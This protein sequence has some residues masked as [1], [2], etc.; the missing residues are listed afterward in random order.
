MADGNDRPKSRSNQNS[1]FT[2]H[3]YYYQQYYAVQQMANAG[4]VPVMAPGTEQQMPAGAAAAGYAW[5]MYPTGYQ[6]VHP[7]AGGVPAYYFPYA[8]PAYS[9]YQQHYMSAQQ[10]PQQV[11]ATSVSAESTSPGTDSVQAQT[12]LGNQNEHTTDPVM[13][14]ST[15]STSSTPT[16]R[17]LPV[18]PSSDGISLV[19]KVS[20]GFPKDK[21]KW[22]LSRTGGSR[23]SLA[24]DGTGGDDDEVFELPP[25]P[26]MGRKPSF[27]VSPRHCGSAFLSDKNEEQPVTT[28][29]FTGDKLHL[30]D[31]IRV[32]AKEVMKPADQALL[33]RFG[34]LEEASRLKLSVF[35]TT[36]NDTEI[37]GLAN[38]LNSKI[39]YLNSV[40]QILLPISPLIQ[41][42]SLSL[43]HGSVG[44]WTTALARAFRLF[45]RPPMGVNPS[46][47]TV[48]GMDSIIKEMG[49]VGTQQD[50]A[51]A[52]GM[53]L[54]RLH[55]EW[56]H[57][58]VNQPWTSIGELVDPQ[59]PTS[60][61]GLSEDSIVYK[62]FRGVR[63]GSNKNLEI[64]TGIHLAPPTSGACSL[65]DLMKQTL[66]SEL[67]YLPPVLC[68]ELSR[69]LSEN[70]LTTSQASV[71]FSRAMQVPQSC[72]TKFCN[73]DRQ[74]ELVGAVVRSGAYANSGHFW[75]VQRRGDHWYWIN[76]TDVSE[77]NVTDAED[78]DDSKGQISAKLEAANNWCVLVYA[79]VDA[80]V[81][82]HPY[83]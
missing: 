82:I 19:R 40:F 3:P 68:I 74:Y 65:V 36:S 81:S 1:G 43:S 26:L 18:A 33:S 32:M 60:H 47:L 76:D 46:L 78:K 63:C 10:H 41:V 24:L 21:S 59:T 83:L 27:S 11:A 12:Y 44:P 53:V 80:K 15:S 31:A 22:R 13:S 29:V 23:P 66:K 45:F 61:H 49:G 28:K 20:R 9:Q 70:Q 34:M 5:P 67:H 55:T 72:C 30:M 71:P 58:L 77:C 38:P 50:V 51:E 75:A 56:H 62:L 39:C 54:D 79:D 73:A 69:H 52:L 57:R 48:A 16:S 35:D 37:T 64:F 14:G 8:H 4:Y 25:S 42:L 7:G 2:M 6:M 17:D